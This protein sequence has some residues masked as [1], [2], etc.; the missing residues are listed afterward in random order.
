[1]L[2]NIFKKT[3]HFT[4]I[5]LLLP[6]F[7]IIDQHLED[8]SRLLLGQPFDYLLIVFVLVILAPIHKHI[9]PVDPATSQ[10]LYHKLQL[11]ITP[12]GPA[13]PLPSHYALP[14]LL[15]L[16]N[17]IIDAEPDIGFMDLAYDEGLL[18]LHLGADEAAEVQGVNGDQTA[19]G[20]AVDVHRGFV[21]ECSLEFEGLGV[22]LV[23]AVLSEAVDYDGVAGFHYSTDEPGN[24]ELRANYEQYLL[25]YGPILK[26]AST[27]NHIGKIDHKLPPK[28]LNI[29]L[30]NVDLNHPPAHLSISLIL[31]ENP[32]VNDNV[33]VSLLFIHLFEVTDIA[34]ELF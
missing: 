33:R 25:L 31:L 16:F 5:L 27:N 17:P 2:F 21:L 9:L 22:S 24:P 14:V 3:A 19:R 20:F 32:L 13:A 30:G 18:E 1:M 23:L 10:P 15:V 7:T 4:F 12:K 6:R 34:F 28:L 26:K 29:L 11:T 8:F